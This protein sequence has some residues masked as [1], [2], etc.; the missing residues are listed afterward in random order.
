MARFL[1]L[2]F[3]ALGL[4][5][6]MADGISHGDRIATLPPDILEVLAERNVTDKNGAMGRNRKDYFHVRFQMGIHHLAN[7]AIASQDT[8]G[9]EHFLR[10]M[11]FALSHQ[12]EDGRFAVNI[13]AELKSQKGPSEADLASGV[14]FFLSSAGLG[15]DALYSSS[16]F[17]EPAELKP[18]HERCDTI[19]ESLRP[20]LAALI[21]DA[22]LLR[23]ADLHA[24]N[25][26][27]FDAA[28]FLSLGRLLEDANAIATGEEFLA[29]ALEAIH[30]DGYFIE[31]GGADTSYNGV[32]A[33]ILLRIAAMNHSEDL[34]EKGLTS[35]AWQTTRISPEGE[36]STEGNTRVR[37]GGE[38]FLGKEKDVDVGHS[39]EALI[40]AS[41]LSGDQE[42]LAT[43]R[44]VLSFYHR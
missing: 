15:L 19:L 25:R 9:I 16:W 35:V 29:L 10:G 26:L 4:L 2:T 40:F 28:A 41:A 18:A 13:P 32:A 24:P 5:P 38:A 6:L 12:Q 33:A 11:E 22:P 44:K 17:Q 30:E 7:F 21:E 43:A 42:L 14:A 1:I 27:L 34:L 36:I 8:R 3:T 20:S 23:K 31:G 39:L 37:P